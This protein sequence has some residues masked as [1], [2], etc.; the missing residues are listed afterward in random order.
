[1]WFAF[2]VCGCGW[3]G[4]H[5]LCF[6]NV[7]ILSFFFI[8]DGGRAAGVFFFM[9]RW[10]ARGWRQPTLFR[11]SLRGR[12]RARRASWVFRATRAPQPWPP[13]RARPPSLRRALPGSMAGRWSCA[14]RCVWGVGAKKTQAIG[15]AAAR[16]RKTDLPPPLTPVSR[17]SLFPR[18]WQHPRPTR[19]PCCQP[20]RPPISSW[21]TGWK[22]RT[23]RGGRRRPT[24]ARRK[25]GRGAGAFFGCVLFFVFVRGARRPG[26]RVGT[27]EVERRSGA[28]D[29][30][31]GRRAGPRC[32]PCAVWKRAN[33]S[34]EKTHPPLSQPPIT[35][36]THSLKKQDRPL[37]PGRVRGRVRRVRPR[38]G[39][40]PGQRGGGDLGAQ[41]R[42]G[43]GGGRRR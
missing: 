29:G 39:P 15:N 28:L 26:R 27:R 12:E 43:A 34:T 10:R 6:V 4:R 31:R 21:A 18:P 20:G 5:L 25:P 2:G 30:W 1:V 37:Q 22:P 13:P 11:F 35:T 14:P 23:T 38:P 33:L 8:Y 19:P 36:T 32:G 41:V 42:G 17:P 9:T 40:G 3:A 24:R 16:A 7:P